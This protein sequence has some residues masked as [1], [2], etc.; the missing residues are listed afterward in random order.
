MKVRSIGSFDENYEEILRYDFFVSFGRKR[1][2]V[3]KLF[4]IE[5][6]Y[7]AVT[8]RALLSNRT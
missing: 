7:V 6:F 5:Q 8:R 2:V 1:R 3:I 4:K